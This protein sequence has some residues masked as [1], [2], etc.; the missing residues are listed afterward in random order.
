[1]MRCVIPNL[2][3]EDAISNIMAAYAGKLC[4]WKWCCG[5]TYTGSFIVDTICFPLRYE[6]FNAQCCCLQ[7]PTQC[8]SI[9]CVIDIIIYLLI[10]ITLPLFLIFFI[11]VDI[12]QIILGILCCFNFCCVPCHMY[13]CCVYVEEHDHNERA[14]NYV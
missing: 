9:C 14:R 5:Q 2:K 3:D 7:F 8:K 10:L 4:E 1:M 12:I 6:N 13:L 11:F